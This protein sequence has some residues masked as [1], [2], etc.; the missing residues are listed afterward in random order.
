MDSTSSCRNGAASCTACPDTVVY[1]IGDIHGQLG[2]L[3]ALTEWLAANVL[4][5]PVRSR[6]L[7]LLGDYIDRGHD[8]IGVL[9]YLGILELPGVSITKLIGNHDLYLEAFL[10]DPGCNFNLIEEWM[11]NG[12]KK[13]LAQLG[14]SYEDFYRDDIATLR[15][16]ASPQIPQAALRCLADLQLS[17]RIGNYLLVHAGVH[18]VRPVDLNDVEALTTLREP[19][20][21]GVRWQHDFVVVHATRFAARTSD[22]TGFPVTAAH[23]PQ[24]FC[25]ARRSTKPEFVS[26]RQPAPMI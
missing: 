19:F 11:S 22:G 9:S 14:L 5:Q 17:A 24:E 16:R 1:A 10:H 26:S 12:G 23:S 6:H 20:L 4:S 3:A 2:H 18:P 21:S 15:S 7:V 13:T 8:G 25:A